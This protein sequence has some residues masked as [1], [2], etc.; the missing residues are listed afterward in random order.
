MTDDE[1]LAAY[2]RLLPRARAATPTER[3]EADLTTLYAGLPDGMPRL[4][5]LYER[6][7]LSYSWKTSDFGLY[8]L[9]A[10][11]H[12]R[13]DYPFSYNLLGNPIGETSFAPLLRYTRRDSVLWEALSVARYIPFGQGG[14]LHYDPVC[15]D[16]NRMRGRDCPV[17]GIDHE[18]ILCYNRVRVAVELAPTFRDLVERTIWEG[19]TP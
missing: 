18:A 19:V 2:M 7:L 13:G 6:L 10:G 12:P 1:L 14:C 17:V 4:P 9:R 15:F 16:L 8:D 11:R 5:R 3:T